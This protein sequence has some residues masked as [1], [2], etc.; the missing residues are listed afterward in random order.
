MSTPISECLYC[1]HL[2]ILDELMIKI[3]DLQVFQLF[4]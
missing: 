3:A 4:L 2:P 1:S